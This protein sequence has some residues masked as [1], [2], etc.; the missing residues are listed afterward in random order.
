MVPMPSP[1]Q[2]VMSEMTAVEEKTDEQGAAGKATGRVVR[3]TASVVDVEFGRH[4]IPEL[5]QALTTEKAVGELSKTLT[6]D[7]AQHIGDDMVRASTLGPTD[8]LVKG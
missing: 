7:V 2:G 4:T 3:G 6:L 1:R 5:N 8:G